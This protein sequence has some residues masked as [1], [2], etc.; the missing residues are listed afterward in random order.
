MIC[1]NQNILID[2]VMVST[3][4][5]TSAPLWI[6]TT[7]GFGI[8]ATW[9]GEATGALKLQGSCS[10]KRP[11]TLNADVPVVI[12]DEEWSDVPDSEFAVAEAGNYL[13]NYDGA[14]FP[15]VR[16]VYTNATAPSTAIDIDSIDS[17][18]AMTLTDASG[19]DP[20]MILIQ[21]AVQLEVL[22]VVGSVIT[23]SSTVGLTEA[24]ATVEEPGSMS[25]N[26]TVKSDEVIG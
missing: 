10:A 20:G 25:I 9:L 3:N 2:G 8:Q 17:A 11:N 4:D 18:T 16:V 7:Q 5:L 13:W 14:Y 21:G 1:Y 19:V 23:V 26:G 15:W 22:T 24:A 12:P 6:G